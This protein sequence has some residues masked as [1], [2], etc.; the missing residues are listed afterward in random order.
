MC[1][2]CLCFS[3]PW[4]G[5][6][7]LQMGAPGREAKARAAVGRVTTLLHG[8]LAAAP[9][10][11]PA[12]HVAVAAVL[13]RA[14]RLLLAQMRVLHADAANGRLQMLAA[15]LTPADA[16][17]TA[18]DKLAARAGISPPADEASVRQLLPISARFGASSPSAQHVQRKV[19]AIA[20]LSPGHACRATVGRI[21]LILTH[22]GLPRTAYV[23]T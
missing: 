7:F 9:A 22:R 15:M 1:H 13:S 11:S 3:E 6:Q 14:L 8:A 19:R 21:V 12:Q 4:A 20:T 17:R 23:G 16:A 18:R 5:L 2:L 10:D